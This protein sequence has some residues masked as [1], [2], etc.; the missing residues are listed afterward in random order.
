[1][2]TRITWNE[3]FMQH[4]QLAAKRSTCPRRSVGAVL[5]RD[6]RLI[7]SGYNGAPPG[8]PHCEEKG[9][10]IEE[11][12]DRCIRTIHAE[13]NAIL[14][15]AIIGVSIK[16]STLY[17]T[18]RPCNVCARLLAGAGL[19]KIVYSGEWPSGYESKVVLAAGIQL[20]AYQTKD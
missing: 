1:M 4:A 9:C 13:Q 10:L 11:R 20:E 7:A 8:Q 3:F 17:T 14:Q 19:Q 15:A 16:D 2:D 6:N 5:V 18:C 12:I